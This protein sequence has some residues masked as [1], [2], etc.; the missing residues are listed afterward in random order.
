MLFLDRQPVF[1]YIGPWSGTFQPSLRASIATPSLERV[2]FFYTAR[3]NRIVRFPPTRHD[4]AGNTMGVYGLVDKDLGTALGIGAAGVAAAGAIGWLAAQGDPGFAVIAVAPTVAVI[5]LFL[6]ARPVWLLWG[7]IFGGLVIT[8][9]LRLYLPPLELIRWVLSPIAIL[10]A[11]Y[12]VWG[13]PGLGPNPGW[14]PVPS[15]IWW[16]LGFFAAVII[17]SAFS[18]FLPSRFIVGF[19][20]YFQVWGLLI[21]L[22]FIP[23]PPTVIDRLPRVF[24][25][26]AFL[27]LPFV[28]HQ[29]VFLVPARA[30]IGNGIV[31][32]DVVA[33][34]F[35]ATM[36]G[37]G[38]N[39]VLNAFLAMVIAGLIAA[40]QLNVISTTKLLLLSVPL[41]LPIFVN[42]AKVSVI[43]LL[44]VFAVLYGK[45]LIERPLRFLL[46]LL[47]VLLVLIALMTSFAL[48]APTTARVE[49][50]QD[51]IHW[52]YEYN[53][54][55]DEVAGELS[56]FGGLRFWIERHGLADLKGTLIGHGVA[57]TRVGDS[58]TPFRETVS[59]TTDGIPVVI[60]LHQNIGNTAV[61]ALLWET[62]LLGLL[63]IIGLL[64]ATYRSAGRVER[65]YAHI[66][67][68]AAALRAAR[69]AAVII[70]VTLVHK[71]V[72]VF[73]VAYQTL[74]M[75]IIGF[76]AYW[77]RQA[78][79]K[80]PPIAGNGPANTNGSRPNTLRSS[81][82]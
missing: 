59:A 27:Q 32:I 33:G 71:N 46:A 39:A 79:L 24:L 67:E 23:W 63:L 53:V 16:A 9:L 70:L 35:G 12:A 29:Y 31:P 55:S 37:G 81:A 2:L 82:S 22:A 41:T 26:I 6:A 52:A 77:E 61:A 72:L 7:A 18:Q 14:R 47:P 69:P 50:I 65:A 10:L 76:V 5:G 21:A 45:D 25:V 43:Y 28:L 64:A 1:C 73:D 51:L 30:H 8:G 11:L 40:H 3:G 19:K 38:A 54:E 36:Q 66:P 62:G 34:S 15:V 57:Y 78:G 56:R 48:H 20:G 49:S 75:I 80:G 58:E 4:C 13:T 74:L 42:E 44:A 68:R 17:A 60:N